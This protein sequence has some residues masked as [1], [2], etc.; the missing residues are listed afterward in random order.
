LFD[1]FSIDTQTRRLL[2]QGEEL[3]VSP[4]AFQLLTLLVENHDRAMSKTELQEPLWPSTYVQ[5][6]SLA[7][8]VAEL[9]TAL[10]DNATEPRYIRTMHRFGYWFVGSP[11]TA[12]AAAPPPSHARHWIIWETRQIP[13]EE[14]ENVI[15][16]APDAGVWI[17]A[18]SVSRHHAR[19][20]LGPGGATV[21]DLGSRNGTYLHGQRL[22]SPQPLAD[23]DQI[24]IGS[25][26]VTFRVPSFAAPTDT[27][28]SP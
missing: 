10:G 9:R 28:L 21:E 14:G 3:H 16:R 26:C 5:P 24:R 19:I 27:V 23:G 2:R 4:K 7:G 13:L 6:T 12:A 15:G 17:D 22:T 1:E 11:R 18:P 25:I 8:L 20:V